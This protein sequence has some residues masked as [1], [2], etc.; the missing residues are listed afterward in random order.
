MK[1]YN[2]ENLNKQ[3]FWNEMNL[4]YPEAVK[5]FN[6]WIKGYWQSNNVDILLSPGA[7]FYHL[8]YEFQMG[9][10]NRFF[11]EAFTSNDE[12]YIDGQRGELYHSE[13]RD[14]MCK[15]NAFINKKII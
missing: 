10:M 14:A 3:S 4:W 12:Y 2:F 13:M 5:V 6:E 11:I 7:K 1:V 15:L 8:P 9:I